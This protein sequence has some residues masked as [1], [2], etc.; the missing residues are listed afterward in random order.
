MRSAVSWL[1]LSRMTE[2]TSFRAGG[3]HQL[4]D[5]E[6]DIRWFRQVSPRS[7]TQDAAPVVAGDEDQ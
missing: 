2:D 6:V 3:L 1:W 7:E 4:A 5:D